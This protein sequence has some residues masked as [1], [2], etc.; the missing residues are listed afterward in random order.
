[1]SNNGSAQPRTADILILGT[2]V[3]G[4]SMESGFP[5]FELYVF[6]VAARL[7]GVP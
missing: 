3:I 2:G 6:T 1:M 5:A 4:A 7:A